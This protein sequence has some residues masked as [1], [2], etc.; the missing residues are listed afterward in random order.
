MS[1]AR[2]Y[3]PS[4][5]RWCEVFRRRNVGPCA[6]P[7]PKDVE[8]SGGAMQPPCSGSSKS[9]LRARAARQNRVTKLES[10]VFRELKEL[11]T[12]YNPGWW[13]S[14]S[15]EAIEPGSLELP[16]FA[17]LG[18]PSIKMDLGELAQKR[19]WRR[20]RIDEKRLADLDGQIQAEWR[21]IAD[22]LVQCAGEYLQTFQSSLVREASQVYEGV[23]EAFKQQNRSRLERARALIGGKK[24]LDRSELQHGQQAKIAEIKARI[25]DLA[26]LTGRLESITRDMRRGDQTFH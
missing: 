3:P 25:S 17:L 1:N 15:R 6:P 19:W 14:G 23:V 20:G 24:Q 26:R 9:R 18:I 4:C 13:E 8:V 2:G 7:L 22:K 10:G 5:A 21:T 16:L 11:L 12:R